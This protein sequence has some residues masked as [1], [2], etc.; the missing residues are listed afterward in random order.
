MLLKGY[1]RHATDKSRSFSDDSS[2]FIFTDALVGIEED[3]GSTT[4]EQINVKV[5]KIDPETQRQLEELKKERKRKRAANQRVGGAAA[6][7]AV[8]GGVFGVVGG[9]V[10]VAFGVAVGGVVGGAAGSAANRFM[11]RKK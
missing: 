8:I 9:P 4:W 2:F 5:I 1:L 11:N 7:G 10:G 6:A 3:G